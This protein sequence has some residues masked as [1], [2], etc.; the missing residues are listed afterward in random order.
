MSV[1]L[2]TDDFEL[3][4]FEYC[5]YWNEVQY[6]CASLKLFL[7][8]IDFFLYILLFDMKYWVDTSSNYS[9]YSVNLEIV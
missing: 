6:G 7:L 4:I 3:M 8:E 2:R 5:D 1:F 9:V